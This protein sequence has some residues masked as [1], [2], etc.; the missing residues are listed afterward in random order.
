MNCFFALIFALICELRCESLFAFA[1]AFPS[2]SEYLF[3]YVK[4]K[5]VTLPRNL[6]NTLINLKSCTRHKE[7]ESY[8]LG[9]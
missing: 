5:V 6:E 3:S 4:K 9:F 1:S 8:D 2:K 7:G